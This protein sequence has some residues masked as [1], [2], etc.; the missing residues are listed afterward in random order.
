[1]KSTSV[2]VDRK[3]FDVDYTTLALIMCCLELK[4]MP[5]TNENIFSWVS[6]SIWKLPLQH[7][8]IAFPCCM[9]SVYVTVWAN[10]LCASLTKHGGDAKYTRNEARFKNSLY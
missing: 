2:I 8:I 1:M 6:F 4:D 3:E 7:F 10:Y 9:G 5:F